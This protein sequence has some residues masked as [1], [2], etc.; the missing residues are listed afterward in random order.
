MGILSNI[1]GKEAVKVFR[2]IGYYIDHQW[3]L[4][5]SNQNGEINRQRIQ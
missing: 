2:K 4:V 5:F 1:S 3:S